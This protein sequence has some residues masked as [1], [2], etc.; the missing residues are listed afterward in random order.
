MLMYSFCKLNI[1]PKCLPSFDTIYNTYIFHIMHLIVNN[2][3]QNNTS[4]ESNS[5]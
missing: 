3:V 5:I 2:D 1:N 4:L